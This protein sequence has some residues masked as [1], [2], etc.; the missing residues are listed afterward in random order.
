M[1]LDREQH[2]KLALTVHAIAGAEELIAGIA[3][4]ISIALKLFAGELS[5][6]V[7]AGGLFVMGLVLSAAGIFTL[8]TLGSLK[9]HAPGRRALFAAGVQA[10]TLLA[11]I[12]IYSEPRGLPHLIP[13]G[14]D[15][16][17]LLTLWR[18]K[19]PR[20]ATGRLVAP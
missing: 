8:T 7:S 16:I 14:I 13:V 6:D 9:Q 11:L 2:L 12:L 4:N 18:R 3:H 17:V 10:T 5:S 19:A 20:E 15:L 1:P